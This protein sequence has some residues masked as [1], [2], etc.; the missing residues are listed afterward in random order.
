MGLTQ[1]SDKAQ[2]GKDVEIGPFTVIHD[3]VVIGD[4]TAQ[5]WLQPEERSVVA[6]AEGKFI[7]EFH[8]L[9]FEE[10][11]VREELYDLSKDSRQQTNMAAVRQD[12]LEE[13]R[14]ILQAYRLSCRRSTS[15]PDQTPDPSELSEEPGV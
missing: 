4:G 1:I 10:P 15:V 14:A 11:P 2:I 13:M 5:C 3:D 7:A 9:E 12:I 6:R 8:E